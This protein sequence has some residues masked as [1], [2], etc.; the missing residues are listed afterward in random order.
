MRHTAAGWMLAVQ[1]AGDDRL[2]LPDGGGSGGDRTRRSG[3]GAGAVV[4]CSKAGRKAPPDSR[5]P[6]VLSAIAAGEGAPRSAAGLSWPEF[7][8]ARVSGPGLPGVLAG[9][10]SAAPAALPA[11]CAQSGQTVTCTFAFTG[12][13]QSWTAP[14]GVTTATVTLDGGQGGNAPAS[15]FPQQPGGKAATVVATIPVTAGDTYQVLAGGA[16]PGNGNEAGGFNGGGSGNF[17][18]GVPNV[19]GGGG[20]ATDIALGTTELVVAGGGGGT[21]GAGFRSDAALAVINAG[22][23]GGA[24]GAP[25]T[26]GAHDTLSPAG[27]HGT[28]GA[29]GGAGTSTV[30]GAGGPAGTGPIGNG[31]PGGGGSA[32]TGGASGTGN[33][34]SG[35]GGG[36]G[37][38]YYGGGGGGQGF[39]GSSGTFFGA[40]GGGGGGGSD[41][42]TPSA[43]SSTVT[44]GVW[45]GN[46]QVTISYT[47]PVTATTTTLV[48]SPN[49][50]VVGQQ[51]TYTATVSPAPDGGT[52]A[53]TDGGTPITGCGAVTVDS[54]TGKAACQ[55][56]YTS[57]GTHSITASYGGD[58]NFSGSSDSL[59]QTVNQ[60]ATT[61]AVT[62]SANPST[63]GQAVT[64]TA[65]VSAIPPGA[66]TPS[67]T[68]TFADGGT[69]LGTATLNSSGAAAIT[70][71][72]LA[73]GTHTITATYNGDANFAGSRSAAL[74]QT[75]NKTATTTT[76][77]SSPNPSVT[78]AQV[79]YTATISPA[80]DGGTVAFTDNG[81]PIAGCTAVPVPAGTA[82]CA[83]TPGTT[84]A[85]NITA[86]YSGTGAF[87]ASTSTTVTQVVTKTACAA[88]AGCNLSGLNL[89]GANLTGANLNSANLTGADLSGATVTGANFNKVTWSNTTCPDGTNSNADGG[90][91]TGHL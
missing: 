30:G 39:D 4:W 68:V 31:T 55:V 22:G 81:S 35:D 14:A 38:G 41:F 42:V 34:T 54:S 24:S 26:A 90:T 89:T 1:G 47:S 62:S 52:V 85:H 13:A 67:G 78:G 5:A 58:N 10:A 64:F 56:T 43:T 57:T 61:T 15:F 76:V 70:T 63:A 37:G 74:T 25:G 60:A 51:V 80:P 49:P 86:A 65:T 59:T 18:G 84:G 29:G 77:A 36:G 66:G 46:G 82:R 2:R 71:S 87:A 48:S 75:V 73:A 9:M 3:P 28:G 16:A 32:G 40:G 21:A 83:T 19:S 12:A 11:N 44:D 45:S 8:G 69:T 72:A 53:F 17:E 7:L 91:C 50:S 79:T 20:G 33:F 23:L 88:L 6:H 27:Q